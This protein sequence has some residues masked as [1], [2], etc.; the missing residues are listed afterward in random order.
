MKKLIV[1]LKVVFLLIAFSTSTLAYTFTIDFDAVP[2]SNGWGDATSYLAGF[3]VPSGSRAVNP[4][5]DPIVPH[6]GATWQVPADRTHRVP[7][8]GDRFLDLTRDSQH[9][10][11]IHVRRL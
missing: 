10:A 4:K 6:I 3:G 9:N 5:V 11:S 1:C 2:T 7:G 8:N